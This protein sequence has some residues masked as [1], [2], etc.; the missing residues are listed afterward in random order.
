MDP[1]CVSTGSLLPAPPKAKAEADG[2][3]PVPAR[4]ESSRPSKPDGQ[5]F[6]EAVSAWNSVP[7]LHRS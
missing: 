5:L 3:L 2:Y 6:P 4:M 7:S 1:A